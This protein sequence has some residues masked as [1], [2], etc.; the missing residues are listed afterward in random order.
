[1]WA[2]G[3]SCFLRVAQPS[4]RDAASHK[5]AGAVPGLLG[6]SFRDAGLARLN[7][8]V[9]VLH[10]ILM[11][12]FLVVPQLLESIAGV[13]R[14]Q[15]WQVYLLTLALSVLAMLPLM[16]TAERGG[17]PRAMFMLGIA[18]VLVAVA[19]LGFAQQAAL[20]YLGLWLFFTGFNYLEATLPSLV[21]KTVF[22]GG[23]GTALG[24]Y[25]SCQFLGAFAGGALGGWILQH[26]SVSALF[27][28][29]VALACLWL[30]VAI[31]MRLAPLAA[32]E[33]L[34]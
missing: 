30:W 28:L 18:L 2:T 9:F 3:R 17:R 32:S 24:V 31:P 23:K 16:R 7:L 5:D 14:E 13:A 12:C 26:Y 8:G 29:C 6:R 27:V 33:G 25:S 10:F 20:V 1:M 19:I 34:E 22:F 15:H 11:A 21:S 4:V